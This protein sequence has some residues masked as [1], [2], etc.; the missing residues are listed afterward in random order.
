MLENRR[1]VNRFLESFAADHS[2]ASVSSYRFGI[3]PFLDWLEE[4]SIASITSDDMTDYVNFLK[5]K[6]L[7]KG[8]IAIYMTALRAFWAWGEKRAKF[9][10]ARD[11][12]PKLRADD[13]VSHRPAA[14]DEVHAILGTFSNS[15]PEDIRN[16]CA[17]M[18]AWTTGLRLCE[19]LSLNVEDLDINDKRG[20]TKT[21]KRKNHRRNIYWDDETNDALKRW[22]EMREAVLAR[23]GIHT[24]ALFIS[25]GT[26]NLGDRIGR[27]VFQIVLRDRSKQLGFKKPVTMHTLRHGFATLLQ[28]INVHH[29]QDLLGHAKLS[30]TQIYVHVKEHEVEASY[31]A[32][33]DEAVKKKLYGGT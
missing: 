33:Y 16:K 11:D 24:E 25:L 15:F 26:S 22:L 2:P 9:S 14:P 19:L 29:L 10:C 13:V 1:L 20:S 3:Y 17:I 18:L 12:I 30:T 6:K 32:N 7:K 8:T 23:A 28:G 4:R 31:R 27:H 21:F 5:G